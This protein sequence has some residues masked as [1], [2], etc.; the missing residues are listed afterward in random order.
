MTKSAG[1]VKIPPP[2]CQVDLFGVFLGL[3]SRVIVM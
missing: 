3:G 1:R 2:V